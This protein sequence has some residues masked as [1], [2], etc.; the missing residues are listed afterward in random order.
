MDGVIKDDLKL[1]EPSTKIYKTKLHDYQKQALS[2]Y[3][4]TIILFF[5]HF[6][7]YIK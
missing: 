2:I 5:Y 3:N 1:S 4:L 6:Y 7:L